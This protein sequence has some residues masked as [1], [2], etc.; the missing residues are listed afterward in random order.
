MREVHHALGTLSP[1]SI[2]SLCR[3]FCLS[4][5]SWYVQL[6]TVCRL[7]CRTVELYEIYEDDTE[8]SLVMELCSMTLT[9]LVN[10]EFDMAEV[11]KFASQLLTALQQ[12][13]T[14]RIVHR[15]LALVQYRYNPLVACKCNTWYRLHTLRK[16][17]DVLPANQV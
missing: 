10:Y 13:Q 15:C 12:L 6:L 3:T 11:S 4:R 14:I 5:R 2:S 17:R 7:G 16:D 1:F 8:Y 9:D